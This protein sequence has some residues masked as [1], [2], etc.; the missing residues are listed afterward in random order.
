MRGCS[1][2]V[3]FIYFSDGLADFIGCMPNMTKIMLTDPKL[4][5]YMVF[6]ALNGSQYRLTGPGAKTNEAREVIVRTPLYRNKQNRRFRDTV[7]VW[8]GMVLHTAS[9]FTGNKK[10]RVVGAMS[11][12]VDTIVFTTAAVVAVPFLALMA[13]VLA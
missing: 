2:M 6:G 4:W 12:N 7:F 10:Y 8:L 5:Y 1:A 9:I 13:R 11:K 3:D